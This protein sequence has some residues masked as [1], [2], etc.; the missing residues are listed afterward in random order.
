M[1]IIKIIKRNTRGSEIT[2]YMVFRPDNEYMIENR[3]R[4]WAENNPSGAVYDYTVDYDEVTNPEEVRLAL[5]MELDT[6]TRE[7]AS[8]IVKKDYLEAELRN[9]DM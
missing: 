4:E 5:N 2:K 8:L 9:Y 1:K 6:V 3:V 7:I